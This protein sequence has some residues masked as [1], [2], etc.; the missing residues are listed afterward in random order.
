[1]FA[2]AFLGPW[3]IAHA[4]WSEIDRFEDGMRIY[5]DR[6]SAKRTG[7]IAE[8]LHLVRWAEPQSEPGQ[9]DYLSTVVHTR[10]DCAGKREQYQASESFAGPMG[11]GKR[12]VADEDRAETW[13]SISEGSMEEKLW[14][15]ACSPR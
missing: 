5:V 6:A 15:A 2:T 1:M 11:N 9:P 3:A 13:D 12:I 10:Y 8:G 7:D 4:D 14:R